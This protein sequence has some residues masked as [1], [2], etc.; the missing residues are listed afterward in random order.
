MTRNRLILSLGMLLFAA[1]GLWLACSETGV[2]PPAAP[3]ATPDKGWTAT[4]ADTS[5]TEATLDPALVA[6][7]RPSRATGYAAVVTQLRLEHKYGQRW[8]E[9]ATL[10]RAIAVLR[11]TDTKIRVLDEMLDPLKLARWKTEYPTRWAAHAQTHARIMERAWEAGRQRIRARGDSVPPTYGEMVKR[12]NRM[13][14]ADRAASDIEL[15]ADYAELLKG[16]TENRRQSHTGGPT[17]YVVRFSALPQNSQSPCEISCDARANAIFWT[18]ISIC[19]DVYNACCRNGTGRCTEGSD[20][21]TQ[22]FGDWND[23]VVDAEIVRD[24]WRDRCRDTCT[25]R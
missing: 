15:L 8:E 22:C 14:Q 23:C 21:Y 17:R 2:T 16:R 18:A 11:G 9:V 12:E 19:V 6:S 24:D 4:G 1:G 10:V 13:T 5:A 25:S 20:K 3:A 7:Q